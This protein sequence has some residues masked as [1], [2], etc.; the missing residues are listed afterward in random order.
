MNLWLRFTLILV[1]LLLSACA[2]QSNSVN[3]LPSDYSS[4]SKVN[5]DLG[6]AYLE[7]GNIVR[8]KQKLLLAIEQNPDSVSAYSA[9]AYFME[10]T[11]NISQA[12]HYYLYAIKIAKHKAGPENNYG[13]FLCRQKD[14]QQGIEYILKAAHD[15][16]YLNNASAYENAG[17]CAMQMK[18]NKLS[19]NYF[20]QALKHDSNRAASLLYL[21]QISYEM[22]D[23][24]NAEAYLKRYQQI[25]LPTI[26]SEKLSKDLANYRK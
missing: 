12:R 3:H 26:K 18:D 22:G 2:T 24:Q 19:K 17:L 6:L 13:T 1:N 15:V 14:Y 25:H 7:Q 4:A 20:L 10:T 23:F 11:E 9:M 21:S 5:V 8:A 16:D